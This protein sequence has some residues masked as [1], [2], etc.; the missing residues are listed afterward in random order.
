M[1]DEPV[2]F[3]EEKIQQ[4][5]KD[6]KYKQYYESV[7]LVPA[8]MGSKAYTEYIDKK[9][10]EITEYLKEIGLLKKAPEEKK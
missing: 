3:W 8:F 7:N 9:N 10:S 6:S 4:V 2:K 5:L 1:P